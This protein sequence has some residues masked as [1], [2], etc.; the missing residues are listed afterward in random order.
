MDNT[1]SAYPMPR[2]GDQAPNFQTMTTFG[3]L[4]FHDYIN[5]KWA[6]LFSHPADFTPVCTTEMSGFALDKAFFDAHDTT[7][8]GLSIDSI[9]AH[10]AWVNNV[11][12]K[13][14]V[15]F[16]F[17]IIADIDMHVSKLY[18]MLQPG[19]SET[20]AVRA[21]FFIDPSKKIRLIMYYPLNVG[22]NM[23]EIKRVLHA[24]QTADKHK[25]SLPLNW[26]EGDQ[27][28]VPPPKTMQELEERLNSD[29][30]MSDFYLAKKNL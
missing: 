28:I 13:M 25:V 5:G 10:I 1:A 18:G 8:I 11:R 15:Q 20:A 4:D 24:L 14:G 30:E 16:N 6:I 12:E 23:E 26:K 27:V 9:H 3:M 22:R 29:L 7:L 19:E 21:V 17:P 2:I